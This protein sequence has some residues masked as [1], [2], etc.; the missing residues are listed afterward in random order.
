MQEPTPEWVKDRILRACE[1]FRVLPRP[2][3]PRMAKSDWRGFWRGF[4]EAVQAEE[5]RFIRDS[6]G[7][8]VY[9]ADQYRTPLTHWHESFTRPAPPQHGAIDEAYETMT[10]SRFLRNDR[11]LLLALWLNVGE[12]L[13]VTDTCRVMSVRLKMKPPSRTIVR[14][15][16][17]QA[18]KLIV[19]GLK[20]EALPAN[21]RLRAKLRAGLSL[22]SHGA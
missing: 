4:G 8:I 2:D 14:R 15:W 6:R 10:W 20:V 7:R 9:G 1:T 3:T 19:E 21:Q 12:S 5:G 16:R 11:R 18:V 22:S 17:D 13:T